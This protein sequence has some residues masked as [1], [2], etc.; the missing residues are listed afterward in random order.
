MVTVADLRQDL[1]DVDDADAEVVVGVP[2]TFRLVARVSLRYTAEHERVGRSLS[3]GD[4]SAN[5]HR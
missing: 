5:T 3:V 2:G 1:L 4:R